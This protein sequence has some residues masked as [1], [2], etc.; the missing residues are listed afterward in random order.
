[1]LRIQSCNNTYIIIPFSCTCPIPNGHLYSCTFPSPN[2][3]FHY[4]LVPPPI[5]TNRLCQILLTFQLDKVLSKLFH[6]LNQSASRLS[7]YS[8]PKIQKMEHN[9]WESGFLSILWQKDD[10]TAILNYSEFKIENN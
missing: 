10:E 3:H 7:S 9:I 5:P 2:R 1:M 6:I 4:D 8:V